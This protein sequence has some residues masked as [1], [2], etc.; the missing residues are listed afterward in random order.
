MGHEG[1]VSLLFLRGWPGRPSACTLLLYLAE[2]VQDTVGGEE[3]SYIHAGV[4]HPDPL[5]G[6]GAAQWQAPPRP[7]ALR[8]RLQ[9][10]GAQTPTRAHER[11][12][13]VCTGT[14]RQ[15]LAGQSLL[16]PNHTA[17]SQVS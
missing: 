12:R 2:D 17:L 6:A 14:D 8:C 10:V 9:Q 11:D 5:E 4:L 3:V 7:A 15:P 1:L 13:C 16:A